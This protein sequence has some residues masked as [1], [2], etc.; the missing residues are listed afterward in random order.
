MGGGFGAG[1]APDTQS[2]LGR[3][4]QPVYLVARYGQKLGLDFRGD[5]EVRVS[6]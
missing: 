3:F 2:A 1:Y 6:A 5:V 4:Q